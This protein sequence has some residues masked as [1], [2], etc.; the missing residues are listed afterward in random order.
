MITKLY[1]QNRIIR[2]FSS[3]RTYIERDSKRKKEKEQLQ[4]LIIINKDHCSIFYD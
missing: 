1:K 3:V 2:K 4:M